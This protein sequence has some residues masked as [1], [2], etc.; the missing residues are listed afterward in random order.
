MAVTRYGERQPGDPDVEVPF[1]YDE[2]TVTGF[3]DA[4]RLN[5]EVWEAWVW[6]SYAM[7]DG[8]RGT[9]KDWIPQNEIDASAVR[10][11]LRGSRGRW[12][13]AEGGA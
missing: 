9:R 7:A 8:F 3:I 5:D 11:S 2:Q 4:R 13:G 1:S 10:E 12:S 6:F